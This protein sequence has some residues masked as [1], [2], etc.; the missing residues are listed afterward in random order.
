MHRPDDPVPTLDQPRR[1]PDRDATPATSR[2]RRGERDT[3]RYRLRR[4]LRPYLILGGLWAGATA[5]HYAG[6]AAGDAAGLLVVVPAGAGAVWLMVAYRR[7]K[8]TGRYAAGLTAGAL[9]CGWVA[10]AGPSWL[11]AAALL[12]VGYAASLRWWRRWRIPD[13]PV[14]P[15][16]PPGPDP[17]YPPR[18]WAAHNAGT[19]GPLPDSRLTGETTVAAG[20]RYDLHLVPG[21]Q[22]L[23]GA[24]QA[25][26]KLRTGLRLLPSQ[27]LILERH[28]VL[29]ES[30][31]SATIVRR[32]PV[33]TADVSW[34][35]RTY[36]PA[37]GTI[38]LG[39]YVDG[40]GI[41]EWQVHTANRLHGGFL[42]GS[43]GSGKSRMLEALGLGY[44]EAGCVVWFG[45][46]QG[47]ASSPFLAEHADDAGLSLD[48][49]RAMLQ[50]ALRLKQYRQAENHLN[51]W[52]GWTPEQ[53]RPGLALVIDE[54]H[55]ATAVKDLQAML[56]VLAREGGKVGI[57][58]VLASQV[59]TL[60]AFGESAGNAADA[61]RSSVCSG[62]L[63]IL[64]S[65]TRNTQRVLPGVDVD[66]TVF[67]RIPGYAYLI[68]DTGTRRTAPFRGWYLTDQA[69]DTAAGVVI[70]PELDQA[71]A[72]VAGESYQNRR[73]LAAAALAAQAELHAAMAGMTWQPAPPAVQAAPVRA[74]DMPTPAALPKWSDY[75]PAA[76]V[77]G[78]RP[79][80]TPPVRRTAV[81]VIAELVAAG[82][83]SPGELQIRSGYGET[84]VRN[85]L[86]ELVDVGRV[87]KVRHGEYEAT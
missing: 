13:P 23:S 83:S 28:P 69:R 44:A 32:S 24:L 16:P 9:W 75:A 34:P 49:I 78:N 74:G 7:R 60:D 86:R 77:G 66:A 35:G 27:D 64:R 41:A 85:A 82:V 73:A 48:G 70:W 51:R 39:P 5:V 71:G 10:A 57:V 81:D 38:T 65:K 17:M 4:Q 14:D 61:L 21:K 30:V 6:R 62:N 1:R 53:A 52:E 79:E 18:L 37:A 58:L 3:M 12:T 76:G 87:R 8:L 72:L 29:D 11:A 50:Q 63:V 26:P 55:Q 19:G 47:G 84:Q 59:A 54:C 22:T 43:T 56:T 42:A 45:D 2:A 46:P 20:E 25:L 80:S 67:P 40:D 31:L 15:A 33:L 68:D 36:D